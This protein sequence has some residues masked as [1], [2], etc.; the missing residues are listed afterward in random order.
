MKKKVLITLAIVLTLALATVAVFAASA[1]SE[2]DPIVAKSYV[3]TYARYETFSIESG[4]SVIG[5]A[6]TEI[7]LRSGDAKAIDN[8][9]DGLADVTGGSD[10]KGGKVVPANHL[11]LCPRDDGRGIKA[12]SVCW[13][14]VRGSYKVK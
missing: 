3:D 14:M 2:N 1:G 7:I 8:G 12:E 6:G 13:V 4:Q 11:L 10:L 9:V 5:G